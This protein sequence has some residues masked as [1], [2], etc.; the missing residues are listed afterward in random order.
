MFPEFV[1]VVFFF[2][3][4]LQK[5]LNIKSCSLVNV[6]ISTMMVSCL[7]KDAIISVHGKNKTKDMHKNRANH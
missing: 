5:Q 7:N 6:T 2:G 1:A 3:F 4:K